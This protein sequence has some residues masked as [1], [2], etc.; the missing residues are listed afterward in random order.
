MVV[1]A[2][3]QRRHA[4]RGEH[5]AG[6]DVGTEGNGRHGRATPA[7]NRSCRRGRRRGGGGHILDLAI[8]IPDTMA[9]ANVVLHQQ[10]IAFDLSSAGAFPWILLL[11]TF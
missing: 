5:A 11:G 7:T 9:L 2:A 6:G 8:A 10:M 4:A 3:E 1:A